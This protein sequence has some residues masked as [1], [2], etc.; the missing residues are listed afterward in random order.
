MTCMSFSPRIGRDLTH[1]W[2][3]LALT[4][5]TMIWQLESNSSVTEFKPVLSNLDFISTYNKTAICCLRYSNILGMY[6]IS[7][8]TGNMGYITRQLRNINTLMG[9]VISIQFPNQNPET[10]MLK[11]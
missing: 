6:N 9:L 10:K 1:F 8:K 3:T 5:K 11:L 4:A 2:R 7:R